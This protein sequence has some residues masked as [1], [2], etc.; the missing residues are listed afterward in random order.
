MT[1][2]TMRLLY[3]LLEGHTDDLEQTESEAQAA[4]EEAL[5]RFELEH[6]ESW[7]EGI[8][9]GETVTDLY[10]RYRK[11]KGQAREAREALGD[12]RGHDWH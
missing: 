12:F 3:D 9:G 7:Y 8:K 1:F 11:A 4:Y 5:D 10:R 2:A 6:E